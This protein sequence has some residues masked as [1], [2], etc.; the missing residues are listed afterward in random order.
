MWVEMGLFDRE[1][2]IYEKYIEEGCFE[3]IYWFTYGNKD[4]ELR[5][6]LVR[7]GKL[8]SHIIVVPCPK[9]GEFFLFR[10]LYSIILPIVKKKECLEL[11]IVKSNQMG[12]AWTAR[13]IAK[14][15]DIPFVLRTGYTFS[16]FIKNKSGKSVL[17]K[18]KRQIRYRF[19]KCIERKLYK[20]CD[21][22][23][24][25]SIHDMKYICNTYQ[26]GTD[27]IK[28]LRNY[29]DCELFRTAES[30]QWKNRIADRIL[31]VG[32]LR[33]QK[34]LKEII[35][36]THN[37]GIGLDI[38]GDGPLWNEIQALIC[39]K[40]VDVCLKGRI[41]NS[42]LPEIYKKYKFYVLASSYEGLPKSLLEAMACGCLCLGTKVEGIEEVIEDGI[43]GFLAFGTDYKSIALKMKKMIE[44]DMQEEIVHNAICHVQQFYSLEGVSQEEWKNMQEI[45]KKVI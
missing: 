7:S 19:Y 35:K 33:E 27:K 22:A 41:T 37:V 15:N 43:T 10:S 42:Q 40:G 9:Y 5:N 12:G 6:E 36:A 26:I 21:I 8:N 31:F 34:N 39:D 45:L 30:E 3:T 18:I 23:E 16:S 1:K 24:V 25:S 4:D 29:I 2:L 32:S 11:A 28:I 13:N 14:E 20:D 44:T 38:Y 17:Q